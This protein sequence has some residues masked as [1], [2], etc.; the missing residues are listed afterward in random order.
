MV[1]GGSIVAEPGDVVFLL[2]G[3]RERDG[4][5]RGWGEI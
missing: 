1:G 4:E 2:E 5:W 3:W